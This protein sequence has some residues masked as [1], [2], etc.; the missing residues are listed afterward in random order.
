MFRYLFEYDVRC[1]RRPTAA[2]PR[3]AICQSATRSSI[4][5]S[6]FNQ[7]S[8]VFEI[9]PGSGYTAYWLAQQLHSLTLSDIAAQS[10]R[11]LETRLACRSNIQFLQWDICKPGLAE[12]AGKKF[13][14]AFGLDIFEYMADAHTAL[15]NL[16]SVL[17]PN[18]ML[19]LFY[20]NFAPGTSHG[21]HY[22][23]TVA[24][25]QDALQ[26]AGFRRWDIFPVR[27]RPLSGALFKIF[28][29]VPLRLYRGHGCRE[30]SNVRN[31]D[32]TWTAQKSGQLERFKPFINSYWD[33]LGRAM[34]FRGSV[35]RRDASASDIVGRQ[36]VIRAWR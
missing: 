9:G 21:I 31:F 4:S 23:R 26:T 13:D 15:C 14:A 32:A 17:K 20:P 34:R 1:V 10:L 6:H 2:A 3:L 30:V 36:L 35:Y 25:A 29:E 24:E 27:L 7:A 5:I 33:M 28:H 18:G 11:S 8:D 22:F 19:L 12:A 16:A